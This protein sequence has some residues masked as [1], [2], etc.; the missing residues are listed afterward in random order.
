M[1]EVAVPL[2]PTDT[3]TVRAVARAV[4]AVA[5]TVTDV[6]LAPSLMLDGDAV[7]VTAGFVSARFKVVGYTYAPVLDPDTPMVSS[8]SPALSLVGVRVKVFVA[9]LLFAGITMS[10][11]DTAA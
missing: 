11:S 4:D 9:P 1:P 6:P 10:K 7:R 3:V 2:P 5:V 8:P